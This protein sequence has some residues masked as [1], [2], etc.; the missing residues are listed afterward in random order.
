LSI[1]KQGMQQRLRCEKLY[2]RDYGREVAKQ[3]KINPKVFHTYVNGSSEAEQ[4]FPIYK[5]IKVLKLVMTKKR[6]MH[7]SF[8]S[9]FTKENTV[10][11]P[12]VI[13]NCYYSEELNDNLFD[14][15][16]IQEDLKRQ[17]QPEK[18]PGSDSLHLGY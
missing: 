12:R 6:R 14:A 3:A 13:D 10:N 7:S 17:C 11:L 8:S 4:V 15:A 1:L 18:L 5:M 9:V 2:L 16:Q